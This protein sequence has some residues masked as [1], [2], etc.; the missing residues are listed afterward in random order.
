VH[1][2]LFRDASEGRSVALAPVRLK[3]TRIIEVAVGVVG[4]VVGERIL[5]EEGAQL[6]AVRR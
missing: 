1:S 4:K 2:N 6:A 5:D 3:E